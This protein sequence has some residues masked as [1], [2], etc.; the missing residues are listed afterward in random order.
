MITHDYES[1]FIIRA[2]A[3][4]EE[5]TRLRTRLQ[6]VI[7]TRGG[8]VMVFEDWGKRKLAYPIEKA[9]YGRYIYM[10][11]VTPPDAP[12]ELE[13]IVRIEFNIVRYLT[14]RLEDNVDFDERVPM[15]IQAQKRRISR[16]TSSVDDDRRM[17]RRGRRP[18]PSDRIGS[19][20]P[21]RFENADGQAGGVEGMSIDGDMESS[22]D[23]DSSNSNTDD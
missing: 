9:E 20:S 18:T 21:V 12:S 22:S 13:R 23:D 3:D 4:E 7:E 14:V 17:D 10:N 19:P 6:E 2:D 5:V 16:A 11:H 1:T 8:K 15:A